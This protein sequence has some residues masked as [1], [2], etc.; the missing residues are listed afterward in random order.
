MRRGFGFHDRHSPFRFNPQT[1]FSAGQQGAFY[2]PSDLTTLFQDSAGITPVTAAGQ[3]VGLMLDKSKGL[4]LGSELVTNGNFSAGSTGWTVVPSW[5]ITS[6]QAVATAT[7]S[8][9]YGGSVTSVSG[10][11]YRVEFD[12]VS[13]TSG[14]LYITVGG[15][16]SGNP[17]LTGSAMA[18][19]R[20]TMYILGGANTTRGV[21]FYGGTITCT[22]DNISVRELAGNHAY[23]STSASRPLLQQASGLSYLDFDGSNDSLL[24]SSVNFTGTDKMTVWTGLLKSSDTAQRVVAELSAT[25]ASNNGAF[26]LSAPNSAAANYNFSSKG[27]TQVDNTVTTYTAPN[28]AVLTGQADI[29]AP[30]NIIRVN[31]AQ[32][33]SVSTTQ[34]TG[35]FGNYPLYIGRRNN[36]TLPFNGRLYGLIVLG[37]AASPWQVFAVEQ[38]MA[39]KTGI[40]IV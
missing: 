30:S 10:R 7:S 1:L 23:Q 39:Q 29:A 16:Y 3:T 9:L 13:Y 21:E 36:A 32:A 2:D 27:T 38:Y 8:S 4:V 6:Q 5:A 19:G 18:A 26:L 17:M 37:A 14:D 34:G 31:G 15:N 11:W 33:G 12:V 22:I 35:N 28:T 40:S 20:K 24:T 25:I